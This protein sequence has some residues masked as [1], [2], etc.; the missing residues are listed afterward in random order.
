MESEF[1]R[2]V[3]PEDMRRL[4]AFD[5]NVFPEANLFSVKDWK[6]YEPY[7]MIIDGTTV[8]CC[9]FQVHVDFQ[10]DICGDGVNPSMKGS[11][12]ISTTGILPTYQGAG[13]GRLFKSW[14][15]AYARYHRFDR[16]VTN[17]RKR[18]ARIIALNKEFGFRILRTTPRYY[19]G[20]TDSTVVM[21]LQLG[22]KPGPGRRRNSH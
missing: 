7:W 2:A 3:L 4:C 6:Q 21:E 1:K 22:A 20:P 16:I 11:L 13:L 14:Q 5:R 10:E 19:S 12:Y 9:A 17:A 8:G 15:V 18:N